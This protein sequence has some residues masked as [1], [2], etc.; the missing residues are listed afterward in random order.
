MY[1]NLDKE[2]KKPKSSKKINTNIPKN[3]FQ[4]FND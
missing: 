2:L 1:N 3:L 4:V